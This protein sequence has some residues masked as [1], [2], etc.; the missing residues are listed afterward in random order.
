[1]TKLNDYDNKE[2]K[3]NNFSIIKDYEIPLELQM[4]TDKKQFLFYDSDLNDEDR[5][6]I[7]TTDENLIH[8]KNS[9]IL[10]CDGTFKSSTSCF[11][12]IFTLQCKLRGMYL[13]PVY[14][15]MK[16]K[17]EISYEKIFLWIINKNTNITN[18]QCKIYYYRFLIGQ[19]KILKRYFINSAIYG[20]NF[21]FVQIVY[22]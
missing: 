15:F 16:N 4:T 13:T 10:L 20:C 2:W 18:K 21:H 1:M 11:E 22:V 7:F 3:N 12:Q 19:V 6:L 14:C 8:V 5:V 9:S 17:K